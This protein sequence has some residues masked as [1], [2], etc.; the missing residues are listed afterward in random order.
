MYGDAS[1]GRSAI[2]T[3]L[4]LLQNINADN[5]GLLPLRNFFLSK[6][7]E[8]INI[9]S[10][11][12]MTERTIAAQLLSILDPINGDKYKQIGKN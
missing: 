1:Q 8:L 6:S 5:P 9:Y 10:K 11:S 2:T 4:T 7:A 12:D 3:C